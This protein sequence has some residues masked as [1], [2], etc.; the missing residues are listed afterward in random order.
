[1]VGLDDEAEEVSGPSLP[2]QALAATQGFKVVQRCNGNC[3]IQIGRTLLFCHLNS[4]L[5]PTHLW[6]SRGRRCFVVKLVVFSFVTN[7]ALWV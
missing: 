7:N 4:K 1:M 6:K 5:T 3:L 2:Y